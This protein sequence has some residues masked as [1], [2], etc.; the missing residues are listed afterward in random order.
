MLK[1]FLFASAGQTI[2]S[3]I[4]TAVPQ[5]LKAAMRKAA[6]IKYLLR[7]YMQ[8][9]SMPAFAFFALHGAPP[10]HIT[11]NDDQE[12]R[13]FCGKLLQGRALCAPLRRPQGSLRN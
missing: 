9:Y 2:V 13:R 10:I 6:A 3:A 1:Q 12:G 11:P 4:V 8:V 5:A 7:P